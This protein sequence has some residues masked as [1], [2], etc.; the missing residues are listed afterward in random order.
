MSI[1]KLFKRWFDSFDYA[2]DFYCVTD[3]DVD[4]IKEI[5]IKLK[6]E[7]SLLTNRIKKL[8]ADKECEHKYKNL[9][10]SSKL[11]GKSEVYNRYDC[12]DCGHKIHEYTE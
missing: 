5:M 2:R 3:Y 10:Y 11:S 12:V 1:D 6:K 8:V 9:V 4:E 7:N